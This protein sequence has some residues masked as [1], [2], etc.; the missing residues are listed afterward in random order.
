MRVGAHDRQDRAMSLP[1]EFRAAVDRMNQ[2]ASKPSQADQLRLYGLYKQ[3]TVG[4]ASG[5]RPGVMKMVER[6]KYDAW[7]EHRGRSRDDAM[8]AYIA[9]AD[10]LGA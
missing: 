7:D 3:S 4:D 6:A 2:R 1:D 9:L 5:D 10:E 8:A